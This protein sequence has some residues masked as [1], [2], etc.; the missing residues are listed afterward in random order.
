MSL[1]AP[2]ARWLRI[3]ALVLGTGLLVLLVSLPLFVLPAVDEPEDLQAAPV[4]AVLVLGGGDG[5]RIGA[6]LAL[7]DRLP[8]PPPTLLLSVPYEAP[9]LSCGSVETMPSVEVRCIVPEPLTTSGEAAVVTSMAA[10]AGWERLVVVTSDFHVTRSRLL[11]SRCT[12]RLA[13]D[14]R[15]LWVAGET[16]AL[17]L[18]GLWRIATEWPSLL[19]TPW[20]HQPPCAGEPDVAA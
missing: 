4:D 16:E 19:G 6:A 15:V 11:F 17:S 14:L 8:A 12:E 2:T 10:A 9:L 20:D 7:L 13:P 5:E 1:R 18:R 3:A